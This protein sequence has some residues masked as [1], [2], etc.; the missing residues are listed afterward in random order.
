MGTEN[1]HA[2]LD[3]LLADIEQNNSLA[4]INSIYSV[5]G[6]E[7]LTFTHNILKILV[8]G[9]FCNL[10]RTLNALTLCLT[11]A[12]ELT[13]IFRKCKYLLKVSLRILFPCI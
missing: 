9:L 2:I 10:Y 11:Q 13:V 4:H 5:S 6:F 8:A 7:L 3:R 12:D 1:I